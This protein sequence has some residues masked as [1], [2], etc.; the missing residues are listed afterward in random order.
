[1]E[2]TSEAEAP[3]ASAG[4]AAKSTGTQSQS[5]KS[6]GVAPGGRR[7]RG[8][9]LAAAARGLSDSELQ[10]LR[11]KINSRERQRMHDLN[12]AMDGLRSV[13]PQQT[14]PS[15]RKLSKIAT[16]M[17]AKNYIVALSRALEDSQRLLMEQ[18]QQQSPSIALPAAAVTVCKSQLEM[19]HQ[20]CALPSQQPQLL[21]HQQHLVQYQHQH[22]LLQPQPQ[23]QQQPQQLTKLSNEKPRLKHSI[24]S[25]IL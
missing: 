12:A 6:A 20:P 8:G 4:V 25:L 24:S 3:P 10:D 22:Q 15:V 23:P 21:V 19:R 18:L 17:L 11:L 1:M 5:T 2:D 9:A 7:R 16:L 13:M 14:G